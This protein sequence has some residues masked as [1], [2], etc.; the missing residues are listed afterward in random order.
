MSHEVKLHEAQTSILRELLFVP[1]AG[2]AV[3]QKPTGLTSDHF[4]FHINRLVELE[5]VERVGRG[6]YRLTING[7]EYANR[8]DTDER[9]IE[10][11]AKI[12]VLLVPLRE[13]AGTD[14]TEYMIHRRLKQPFY[15]RYGFMSGK[16]RWGE[17]IEEG[18]A[19]EL[20]EE[21]GLRGDLEFK[22][23][24][25]KRDYTTGDRLLEDKYFFIMTATNVSGDF[26]AN[27]DSG[28]NHWH[29]RAEIAALENKFPGVIDVLERIEQPNLTLWE[30]NYLTKPEDY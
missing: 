1:Q 8:L 9:T 7:K 2:F 22:C 30:Q 27:F 6:Q 28:S 19:R 23:I 15:G 24:Y 29:T 13:R 11:Q 3:L 25:H 18:A 10:R 12:S 21:T 5:L 26:Q 16:I 20:L 4:M 17:S 14:E